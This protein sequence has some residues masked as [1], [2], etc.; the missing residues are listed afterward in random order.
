MRRVESMAKVSVVFERAF[1]VVAGN[2]ER[3][4]VAMMD[5]NIK[6]RA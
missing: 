2:L 5:A 6:Y 1:T 3:V 4:G